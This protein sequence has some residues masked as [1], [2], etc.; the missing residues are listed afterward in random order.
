MNFPDHFLDAITNAA[1]ARDG[2][3]QRTEILFRCPAD[4]HEDRHPS[5]RW[6]RDKATWCCDVCKAGGGALD[7]ADRFGIEKPTIKSGGGGRSTFENEGNG[8]TPAGCTLAQYAELKRLPIE[9]LRS[10]GL[11]E[12]NYDR[13]PA[14]RIPY[15]DEM[16]QDAATQFRIRLTKGPNGEDRFKWKSGSKTCLYG[17]DRIANARERRYIVIVEGASDCHTLWYHQEPAVG[18]PGAANWKEDRDA[19]VIDGIETVFVVIEP[20]KGG[21]AVEKWVS[22]SRIRSRVRLL[23]LGHHK[24]PSGLYLDDPQRFAERWQSYLDTARSFDDWAAERSNAEKDEAWAT[25]VQIATAPDILALIADCLHAAGMAGDPRNRKLLY[26]AVTSRLLPKPV[27]VAVK[28]PS[29]AGKS[30]EVEMVL[31]LFPP[32]AYYALTA[33]SDRALAYSEEPLRHRVLVLYE[34]AGMAGEFASYLMRSLLSEGRVRYETVEHTKDGLRPRVIEREGP[35]GLIVTTTAV[36]L[37]PENET[38][39]LSLTVSDSIEQTRHILRSLAGETTIPPDFVQWHALQTFLSHSA[40]RVVIPYALTL[41]DAIPPVA[42]RLRRDAGAVLNLIRAHALL[43]QATRR[44]DADGAVVAELVDYAMVRA[45]IADII[46]D[47]VEAAVP[48]TVRET[49]VTVDRLLALSDHDRGDHD[50]EP[51]ISITTI[52]KALKID[53]SAASRRVRV[54]ID[55]EYLKNLETRKGRPAKI[56]L[57]DKLPVDTPIL[58]TI[59]EMQTRC[60]VAGEQE[61]EDDPPLGGEEDEVRI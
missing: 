15:R 24:D 29:A 60:S 54:A 9:Q 5:A 55:R 22:G 2:K 52:S 30:Y 61:G 8:A 28:G 46:A 23:D 19:A 41:V 39:L 34:A 36:H 38:R 6:N 49:V 45:L 3:P 47:G 53:K 35:T 42:V 16:G 44:R 11:S 26:L 7:L 13:N 50:E 10:F 48:A 59:E 20:D 33:M 57:G 17:R 58:P 32:S 40:H 21:E 18:L 14:V 31:S 4:G 51:S 1:L 43:H 56:A 25:C 37:H 27:S 12:I